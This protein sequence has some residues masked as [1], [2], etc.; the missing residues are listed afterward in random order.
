MEKTMTPSNTL[1]FA[2]AVLALTL[3]ANGPSIGKAESAG[4]AHRDTARG[5][6]SGGFAIQGENFNAKPGLGAENSSNPH[7]TT[8]IQNVPN[9]RPGATADEGT[10]LG[11]ENNS[12][13]SEWSPSHSGGGEIRR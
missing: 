10:G 1:L 9:A 3:G 4:G 2:T 11:A 7:A 8:G 13:G 12:M 5:P 6:D